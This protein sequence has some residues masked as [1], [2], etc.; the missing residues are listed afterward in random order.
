VASVLFG[1]RYER[2]AREKVIEPTNTA[3]GDGGED[4]ARIARRLIE[5]SR[6]MTLATADETG[7]PWASPVFFSPDTGTDFLWVSSPGTRHSRNV[8]GRTQVS[9]V[10][11]DTGVA[12]GQAQA[13]YIEAQAALV[14]DSELETAIAAYSLG[15]ERWGAGVWTPADVT[16]SA[17][18]RLYRAQGEAF[19]VLDAIGRTQGGDIRL[20]IEGP[21]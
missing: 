13:L 4:L 20:P 8:A 17:D 6:Y 12:I 14:P 19:S 5:S 2:E 11:F 10:L 9:V 1:K 15:S 16:G 21:M 18:L 3:I 7:K